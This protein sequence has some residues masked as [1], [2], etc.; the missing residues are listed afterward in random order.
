MLAALNPSWEVFWNE[1]EHVSCPV[2]MGCPE[3]CC[4]VC[5]GL[6]LWGECWGSVEPKLQD[7]ST[8][9]WDRQSRG[10]GGAGVRCWVVLA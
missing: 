9:F 6:G 5:L 3:Q 7:G 2:C 1:T 8:L 10:E 4:G